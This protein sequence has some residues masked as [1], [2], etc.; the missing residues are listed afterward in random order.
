MNSNFLPGNRLDLLETGGEYFPALLEAIEEASVEVRLEAYIF[1]NDATGRKVAEALVRAAER[2]VAV[3]VLVD[4]FGARDF[5]PGLGV[6]LLAGGVEVLIYGPD[7]SP[8]SLRR[9]RLRRLHRKLVTI[10]ARIAFTGGIN[11][12]DDMHTPG[13]TPPRYD[14]QVRIEGPLL[15]PIHA[16][17]R[18]LWQLVRLTSL[19]RRYKSSI[20]R[21]VTTT[22]RGEAVAAFVIRDNLRHRRD[23]EDAYLAAIRA[24]RDQILLANAYFLPGRRFRQALMAAA[25]R[26][27]KVTVLLQGHVEYLL[28]HY[29]TQALYG[30]LLSAGVH[31]F[32]YRRSF[33]H[34]KVAVVDGAW[35]T[36]GSSNIDPFS[37]LLARE[38][39]V[40]VKDPAFAGKLLENMRRA[41]QNGAQEVRRED[42]K[43]K[44][45]LVRMANWLAYTLVR[46]M[47]GLAGYAP[48]G[49]SHRGTGGRLGPP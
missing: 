9:H 45:L 39:N 34:A 38:A 29:A 44:P 19:P 26:G 13:Q 46:L 5:M 48:I 10:D 15:A 32:E 2:G 42:W 4:G 28:L 43:K 18:H 8:F 25:R 14:Y 23:I 22:P 35:A 24:A 20:W 33:L 6:V 31:I 30:V 7:I 12:I 36:V 37:L 17:M 40:V 47:V 21:A 41:M 16:A 27:V 49:K 3:H 1:E 11:I